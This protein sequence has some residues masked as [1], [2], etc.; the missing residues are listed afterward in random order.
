LLSEGII[1]AD[2]LRKLPGSEVTIAVPAMSAKNDLTESPAA[3]TC[4]T[5]VMS[6]GPVLVE[7]WASTIAGMPED[8]KC[9]ALSLA[10][11]SNLAG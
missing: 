2:D 3:T 8:V 9:I 10:I 7:L 5:R 11:F 6:T 4:E 1:P